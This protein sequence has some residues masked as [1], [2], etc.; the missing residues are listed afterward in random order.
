MKKKQVPHFK[1]RSD[2]VDRRSKPPALQILMQ[3]SIWK[4]LPV[5][6]AG[7]H[8]VREMSI[9]PSCTSPSARY[10]D[11]ASSFHVYAA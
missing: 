6:N 3:W 5:C 2:A 9:M 10:R 11:P 8:D 7:A 1:T 4:I